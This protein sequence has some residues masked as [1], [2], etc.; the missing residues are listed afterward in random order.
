MSISDRVLMGAALGV[1]EPGDALALAGEMGASEHLRQ[2]GLAALAEVP[3][4]ASLVPPA[5][6]R[7]SGGVLDAPGRVHRIGSRVSFALRWPDLPPDARC[8]VFRRASD[9]LRRLYPGPE[10]WTPLSGFR[11]RE[12]HPLLELALEPPAGRQ[13][14][15]VVLVSG[16]L[17]DRPW[18][19]GSAAWTSLHSAFLRGHGYGV[20]VE[21][22]IV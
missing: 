17:T 21:L 6:E 8:A 7:V 9:G 16:A 10:R 18:S 15:D 2:S 3:L 5:L 13:Q 22:H 1:L 19:E 11:Q 4:A 12:G 14:I 20:T